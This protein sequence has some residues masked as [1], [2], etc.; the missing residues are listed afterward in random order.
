LVPSVNTIKMGNIAHTT[1]CPFRVGGPERRQGIV[2]DLYPTLNDEEEL[3]RLDTLH[4][5]MGS[6]FGRN[7]IAPIGPLELNNILDIGAGSGAWTL[8]VAHEYPGARVIGMDLSPIQRQAV[9]PNCRFMIGDLTKDLVEF[10]DGSFDLV[11]SRLVMAGIRKDQWSGYI[12]EIFRVLKP[13]TGWAQCAEGGLPFWDGPVP[14][15]SYYAQ[16]LEMITRRL[17]ESSKCI[18]HGEHLEQR[19]RDTG[20]VDI[21]VIKKTWDIG[22]W[23]GRDA[24]KRALYLATQTIPEGMVNFSD[25]F[26]DDETRNEFGRNVIKELEQGSPRICATTY[27]HRNSQMHADFSY[28]VVGRKPDVAGNSE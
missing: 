10:H 3:V 4:A 21:N 8:E 24:N 13:G 20:F 14:Q 7:V 15:D 6:L 5:L 11:H 19:F 25:Q 1:S 12:N 16:Y 26:P 27:G 17:V 22:N 18:L 9:P 2:T 23:R 28:M